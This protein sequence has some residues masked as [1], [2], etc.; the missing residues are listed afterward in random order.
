MT[1]NV[2]QPVLI[3][4]PP[5][6]FFLPSLV[7]TLTLTTFISGNLRDVD[8]QEKLRGRKRGIET[9]IYYEFMMVV[10]GWIK[11]EMC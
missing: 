9:Q 3:F 1:A 10:L 4:P 6:F 8:K 7:Q 5:L 2:I 11:Q